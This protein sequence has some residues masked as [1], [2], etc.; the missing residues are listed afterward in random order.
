MLSKCTI[1]KRYNSLAF[2]YPCLTNLPKH[3]MSLVNPYENTGIDCTGHLWINR[4]WK[5]EKMY[6]LI[7]TCLAIRSIHKEVVQD[8]STKA[9]I[10][11]FIRFCNSYKILSYIY[12]DNARSFD[13]AL[14][15]DI[16][17]HHLDSNEFRNNFIS[18]T[19]N[20]LKIPLYSLWMGSVCERRIK[21]TKNCLFKTL[22][23]A[24]SDYF[25]LLTKIS[26]IQRAINSRPLTYRSTSDTEVLPLTP[27]AFLHRNIDGN[28]SV[29][30]DSGGCPDM[31]PT[32][33]SQLL[34][35]LSEREKLLDN[36][37]ELWNEEYLLSQR[38]SCNDLNN[39]DFNNNIQV[40]DV[41]LIKNPAKTRPFWKLGWVTELFQGYDG[42]IRSARITIGDASYE[43][44][45]IQHLFPMELSLTHN[46]KRCPIPESPIK[47][48]MTSSQISW[49]TKRKIKKKCS[50]ATFVHGKSLH[51]NCY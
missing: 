7:F 37:K 51:D 33:R 23:R 41:E 49:R 43:N 12:S 36:F 1:C 5:A 18:H 19:I 10:Q 3:C 47:S 27:N 31:E 4:N 6:L 20:H 50:K 26:D 38:E 44:R 8:I 25:Q 16:L 48:Q 34:D 40:N 21:T 35:V 15:K 22:G 32:S 24:K 2:K 45:N 29:K 42:N 46:V 13:N 17:E 9:F 11:A 39:M 14:G 28:I 30:T